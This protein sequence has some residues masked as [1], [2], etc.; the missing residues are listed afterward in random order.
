VSESFQVSAVFAVSAERLYHAWLDSDE[1]SH[2]TGSPAEIEPTPGGSFCAWD[3]YINGTNLEL[4]PHRR[5][6]QAWRTTDFPPGCPDSRLEVL[7]K[8]VG[9]G[10]E[11]TLIHSGLPDGQGKGYE[12]GWM[13]YYF[14]PMQEYFAPDETV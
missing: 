8:P 14:T 1:H 11:M 2:F 5:I 3:G 13:D 10:T 6:V 9:H 4:E 7:F 12:Q